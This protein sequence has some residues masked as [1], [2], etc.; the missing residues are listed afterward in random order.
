[1][2]RENKTKAKKETI[3]NNE[4]SFNLDSLIIMNNSTPPTRPRFKPS[5]THFLVTEPDFSF[6]NSNNDTINNFIN[7]SSHSSQTRKNCE[8]P[9][10]HKIF[11]TSGNLRNH[12]MT[13]HSNYRPF[14]CPYPNCN[15]KYTVK[16]RFQVH[17]RTHTGDKPFKCKFCSKSFNEK[18][19]LKTHLIFHSALRPYACKFCD[20][21]YKSYFHLKDHIEIKH[22]GIKKYQCE[23]CTKKFGRVSTLKSHLKIHSNVR[24]FKCLVEG[25]DKWFKEKGNMETHYLRHLSKIKNTQ[26]SIEDSQINKTKKKY[27]EQKIEKDYED[28]IKKAIEDLKKLT[29][30]NNISNEISQTIGINNS[31][32]SN[33]VI[34]KIEPKEN[35][36]QKI[37]ESDE[38]NDFVND[39]KKKI[40]VFPDPCDCITRPCSN[41]TL[42]QDDKKIYEEIFAKDEDLMSEC[43]DEEVIR[44]NNNNCNNLSNH[45]NNNLN[46]SQNLIKD[47]DGISF[48]DFLGRNDNNLNLNYSQIFEKNND[49]GYIFGNKNLN[50]FDFKFLSSEFP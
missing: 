8:C 22:E 20:K 49:N 40:N 26:E 27:G 16:S 4:N 3:A 10:C 45:I 39:I 33:I 38:L 18:G 29:N 14:V 11:S 46:E 32:N 15:K 7:M 23:I 6:S 2:S 42:C 28:K 17:L 25:C 31:E 13:I 30:I 48:G 47:D 9:F 21:S 43:L 19:N 35:N 1:M 44:E 37:F 5:K 34:K 41:K 12:C 36:S 24:K 50:G